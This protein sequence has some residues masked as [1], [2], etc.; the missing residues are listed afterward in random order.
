MKSHATRTVSSGK[1]RS[2]IRLV[3]AAAIPVVCLI[4][5]SGSV[6]ATF[7]GE[8]G[9]IAFESDREGN[10]EIYTMNPD[11]SDQTNISQNPASD[12]APATSPDGKKIAFTS[13]RDGDSDI[14][15]MNADGSN[16]RQITDNE[17]FDFGPA[18]S[19]DGRR[20]AFTSDRD[21]DFDIYI[22]NTGN[23]DTERITSSGSFDFS[24]DFSPDGKSIAFESDRA[25]ENGQ[26]DQEVYTI[27]L[28]TDVV[29][30]VSS[31]AG[32]AD[33][34][35]SY[36]PDGGRIAFQS[37]RPMSGTCNFDE[38]E[39]SRA[40]YDIVTT[41]TDGTD[42]VRLTADGPEVVDNYTPSWSPDGRKIAYAVTNDRLFDQVEIFKMDSDDG[43]NKVRLTEN[44]TF[45]DFGPDW[46][47]RIAEETPEQPEPADPN[48]CTVRGTSGN[49]LLRGTADR[50]VICGLGGNDLISGLGGN[51][52]LRGGSGND[53]IYGGR[54]RDRLLGENGNDRLDGGP[55]TD[56]MVGGPGS[57]ACITTKGDTESC[58]SPR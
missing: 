38:P 39:A 41:K 57:D 49:D 44:P 58:E 19:P 3:P 24:P 14:Y 29:I 55:G 30:N 6:G 8:N 35:P 56:S 12:N 16:V 13:D 27:N 54:G 31:N 4:A 2:L 50:D 45:S 1:S 46:G 43:D 52:L 40:D 20:I 17:S 26:Q 48:A 34:A 33:F 53:A 36:S 42:L 51:D 7:P 18:W 21:D 28:Q 25:N 22:T 15:T 9:R 47:V 5:F 32:Q 11:G 10:S 37:C 23:G